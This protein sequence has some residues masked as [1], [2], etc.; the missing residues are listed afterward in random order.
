MSSLRSDPAMRVAEE[1]LSSGG[2]SGAGNP[3]PVAAA[4]RRYGSPVFVRCLPRRGRVSEELPVASASLPPPEELQSYW[5]K[6]YVLKKGLVDEDS[7][8][9]LRD[10]FKGVTEGTIPPAKGMLVMRDVLVA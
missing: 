2:E 1:R 8:Q 10:R 7:V 9:T 5:T 6:G 3:G 4:G